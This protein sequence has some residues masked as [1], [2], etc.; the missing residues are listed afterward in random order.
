M[1][2]PDHYVVEKYNNAKRLQSRKVANTALE[3]DFIDQENAGDKLVQF[4]E[5]TREYAIFYT[6]ISDHSVNMRL[7]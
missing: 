1:A 4:N 2:A 7:G 6:L 3:E 5:Q